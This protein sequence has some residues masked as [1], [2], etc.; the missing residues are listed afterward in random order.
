MGFLMLGIRGMW[1]FPWP[2]EQGIMLVYVSASR[3]AVPG[4]IDL[5]ESSSLPYHLLWLELS[6]L[7]GSETS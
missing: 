7:V 3:T 5:T 1:H 2:N 6:I 4:S